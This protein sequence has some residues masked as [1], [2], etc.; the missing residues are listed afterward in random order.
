MFRFIFIVIC[1]T[2]S[3]VSNESKIIE[4]KWKPIPNIQSYSIQIKNDK[5]KLVYNEKVLEP[6]FQLKLE[7]G[8]YSYRVGSVKTGNIA[9]SKWIDIEIKVS[10]IPEILSPVEI[11][12]IT[13]KAKRIDVKLEGKNLFKQSKFFLESK[14]DSLPVK[15]KNIINSELDLEIDSSNKKE[16]FYTL[17]IEN[18]RNKNLVKENYLQFYDPISRWEVLKRSALIPGWGQNYRKDK[19]WHSWFYPISL[20]GLFS[21]Y[22]NSAI[23]NNKYRDDYQDTLKSALLFTSLSQN[24]DTNFLSI[25]YSYQLTLLEREIKNTNDIAN[26]TLGVIG[27]IYIINLLDAAF[28]HKYSSG[29]KYD[30]TK[31]KIYLSYSTRKNE[32][33]LESNESYQFKLSWSF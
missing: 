12:E 28:F 19:H 24:Q 31:V 15:V 13:T 33:F 17:R 22:S 30:E 26:Q 16:E 14:K 3:I 1:I 18:P 20:I 11:N 4:L 6:K 29:K 2:H 8:K 32:Y 10:D 23:L 27:S 21:Y 7:A 25:Q 9:Y 5:G